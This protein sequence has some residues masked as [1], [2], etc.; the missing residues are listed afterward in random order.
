MSTLYYILAPHASR[1]TS[2]KQSPFDHEFLC[3]QFHENNNS[4]FICSDLDTVPS[5]GAL[6]G[7]RTSK[8]LVAYVTSIEG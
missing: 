2:H 4:K 3:I 1:L 5:F 7:P 6:G 8:Y